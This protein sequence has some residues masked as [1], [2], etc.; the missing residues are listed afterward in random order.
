[1]VTTV[2]VKM[3]LNFWGLAATPVLLSMGVFGRIHGWP[4]N[5]LWMA[6]TSAIA[7]IWQFGLPAFRQFWGKL[8]RHS[9][10]IIPGMMVMS[11]VLSFSAAGI[12]KVCHL[13]RFNANPTGNILQTQGLWQNIITLLQVAGQIVGEEIFTAAIALPVIYLVSRRLSSRTSWWISCLVSALIFGGIHLTTYNWDLYQCFVVIG[14]T[15]IPF[16]DAWRKTNSL[17]GGVIAHVLYDYLLL[18]K[19]LF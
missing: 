15:R 19:N 8:A 4:G 3:K 14:L 1:M 12:G 6:V 13:L 9:W 17:W 10:L 2:M 16:N 11:L 7:L 18:V 5:W